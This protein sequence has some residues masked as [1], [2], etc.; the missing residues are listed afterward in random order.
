M[1]NMENGQRR[2]ALKHGLTAKKQVPEAIQLETAGLHRRLKAELAPAS[3]IEEIL[4]GELARHGAALKFASAAEPAVLRSGAACGTTLHRVLQANSVPQLSELD[5][6][7][8]AAVTSD[9]LEKLSRYRRQHERGLYEAWNT[10]ERVHSQGKT[11]RTDELMGR[12]A[13][14]S[15]CRNYLIARLKSQ[16]C[17]QCGCKAGS[18]LKTRSR[19]ECGHCRF[20]AGI[21]KRHAHGAFVPSAEHMV[22]GNHRGK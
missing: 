7:L 18:W 16:P 8:A 9:G 10:L 1:A 4:V 12:F 11:G 3:A 22:P 21:R 15:N 14:E 6:I 20:Q 17:T 5:E 2:N 19:W 13:E